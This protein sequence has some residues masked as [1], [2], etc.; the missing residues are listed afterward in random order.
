LV[1]LA[2][3]K[4]FYQARAQQILINYKLVSDI[5]LDFFSKLYP[6]PSSPSIHLLV[7]FSTESLKNIDFDPPSYLTRELSHPAQL[8]EAV[9]SSRFRQKSPKKKGR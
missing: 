5:A 8:I 6:S 9:K 1:D 7:S 4:W 2:L 3:Q